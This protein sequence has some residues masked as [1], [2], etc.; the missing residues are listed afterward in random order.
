ML[1]FLSI[2][3][4]SFV[5]GEGLPWAFLHVCPKSIFSFL[6]FFFFFFN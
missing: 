2:F 1:P 6:F 4:F 5:L 3:E